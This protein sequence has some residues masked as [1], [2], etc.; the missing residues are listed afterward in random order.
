MKKTNEMAT[1]GQFNPLTGNMCHIE[2]RV[3]E[4][5]NGIRFVKINRGFI[6]IVWLASHGRSVS[7]WF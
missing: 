5:E 6:S 1:I 7:V 3:Y 2:R 4:D